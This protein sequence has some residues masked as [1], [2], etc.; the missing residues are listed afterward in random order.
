MPR[1][2]YKFKVMFVFYLVLIM[3]CSAWCLATPLWAEEGDLISTGGA[4]LETAGKKDPFKPFIDTAS[5]VA[6]QKRPKGAPPPFPSAETGPFRIQSGG[7]FG[8]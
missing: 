8:E 7:N 6:K 2:I 3:G 1:Q 4:A 5:E